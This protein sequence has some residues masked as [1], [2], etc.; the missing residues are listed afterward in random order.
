MERV[1][2]GLIG[3][4]VIS[5]IYLENMTRFEALEVVALADIDVVRAIQSATKYGVPKGC[6]VAELLADPTIEIVVNLTVPV[7]HAEVNDAI[8]N[9][10]KHVY[11][12]KPLGITRDEASRTIELARSKG[13]L[14]GCAPDT[15]L[16]AS[17]QSCRKLIDD[18]A[19]G[20]PIGA[21]SFM[22]GHG[23]EH[24]VPQPHAYYKKGTGPLLD[25]APYYISAFVNILGPVRRVSGSARIS[26]PER[27]IPSGPRKG[28]VITV[29]TPTHVVGVLDFECGAVV[30]LTTSSDVWASKL[31]DI[32]IYGSEG[33]LIMPDP[34]QFSGPIEFR[35]RDGAW[36]AKPLTHRFDAN[37]RGV[38]VLDMAYAIRNGRPHRASGDLAY[39]AVEVMESILAASEQGRS[40]E[41]ESRPERPA[42]MSPTGLIE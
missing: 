39:H 33:T 12:E 14:V 4:G 29:E 24:W 28:E 35:G 15:F 32:E 17:M 25:M 2:V 30:H 40:I 27:V 22:L 23:P 37:S 10:G 31:P 7:V 41:I 34:N 16:G 1:R 11:A 8:L 36:H 5:G 26:F 6:S 21:H 9:A 19:I 3:C 38:G 18:G 13:L 42:P 20:T